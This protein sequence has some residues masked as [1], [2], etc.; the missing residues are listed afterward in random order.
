MFRLYLD[1][2]KHDNVFALGGYLGRLSQWERFED[3]WAL[4]LRLAE[5]DAFHATDFNSCRGAF[6]GWAAD[7]KK[8]NRFAKR[9]TAIAEKQTEV[10]VGR[11]VDEPALME[12]WYPELSKRC[13]TPHQRVTPLMF[14]ARTCLEW[15]DSHYAKN[16][17]D[18]PI[19]VIFEEGPGVGEAIDYFNGLRRRRVPWI[20]RFE[21]FATGSKSL[22]PLQAADLIVH[23]T[24]RRIE[25]RLIPTGR[26]KRKSYLRL[27]QGG[28][29]ESKVWTRE[30]MIENLSQIL[31]TLKNDPQ[32]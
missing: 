20:Q 19:A 30:D 24:R 9:F 15:I 10:G 11:A 5:V 29:V 25:E 31:E 18:E 1:E 28:R 6:A 2:S 16:P 12:I 4:A 7:R 26:R 32:E 3:E 14:C 27:V 17:P 23:E 21:S 8:H 13:W 22:L